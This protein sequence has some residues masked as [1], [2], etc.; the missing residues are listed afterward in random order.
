VEGSLREAE[1]LADTTLATALEFGLPRCEDELGSASEASL[2]AAVDA[3]RA[4]RFRRL[5]ARAV[6]RIVPLAEPATDAMP[7]DPV[8]DRELVVVRYLGSRLTASRIS[9]ELYVSVNTR[10]V[11]RKL[12]VTSRQAAVTQPRLGIREC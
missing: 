1:R 9:Q 10:A 5:G 8:T 11:C 4:E 2:A 3:V 12:A 7:V 6:E